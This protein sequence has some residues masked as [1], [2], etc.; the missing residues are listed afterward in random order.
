[1]YGDIGPIEKAESNKK[2]GGKKKI[3]FGHHEADI[4]GGLC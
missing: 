3:K 1:M 4:P 2:L